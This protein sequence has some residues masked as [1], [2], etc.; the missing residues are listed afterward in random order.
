MESQGNLEGSVLSQT[1]GFFFPH[2]QEFPQEAKIQGNSRLQ[3]FPCHFPPLPLLIH[4]FWNG[5]WLL[6]LV[7]MEFCQG[8]SLSD[9]WDLKP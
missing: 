2:A 7:F 6:E 3:S 5:M 4:G 9:F 8:I 1:L